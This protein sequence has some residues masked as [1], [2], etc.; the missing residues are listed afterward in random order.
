MPGLLTHDWLGA[1][2]GLPTPSLGPPI[3][4]LH[5]L[6]L[7]FW[8]AEAPT[9]STPQPHL[10]PNGEC[11]WCQPCPHPQALAQDTTTS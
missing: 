5:M 6:V 7:F 11:K 2:L 10:R 1:A 9:S 4:V 8:G 3:A